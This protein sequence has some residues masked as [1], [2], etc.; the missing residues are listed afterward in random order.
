MVELLLITALI[1][2]SMGFALSIVVYNPF[3]G[4][5]YGKGLLGFIFFML[6]ITFS[7]ALQLIDGNYTILGQPLYEISK[8]LAIVFVLITSL[9]FVPT[10]I[11]R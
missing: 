11:K 9:F 7:Y 5:K 6:F 8:L 2:S 4:S 3:K 1:L 10:F